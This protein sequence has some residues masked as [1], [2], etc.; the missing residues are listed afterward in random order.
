MK[1]LVINCGS[2]SVKFQFINTKSR[3]KLASGVAEM[4]AQDYSLFSYKN[5]NGY[6]LTKEKTHFKDHEEAINEF[7]KYIESNEYGVIK[8]R[9]EIDGI[10]HRVV[11]G[12]EEFF[13]SVMINDKLIQVMKNLSFLAPLH[14]PANIIGIEI[15]KKLFP[16]TAQCGVFDTAFHHNMPKYAFLYPIPLNL[17]YKHKI[18]K[19]GFHGTS[20]RFVYSRACEILGVDKNSIKAISCHL[21]NGASLAAINNGKSLDTS[22]GLTP[23][24]GLM[25]G[26]RSG[27]IDPSIPLFM[28][29]Q[30][31]YSLKQVSDTL[32]KKSGYYG[33][34][35]GITDMREIHEEISNNNDNC[36]LALDIYCYRLK[37]YIAS[38]LAVLNGADILIFTGGVG[39]ND[40]IV[41]ENTIKNIDYLGLKLDLNK[42]IE[43]NRKE[44]LISS[45]DS[46]IPI[47]IIPTD[48]E[49]LIALD[50]V[51]II[52]GE[53]IDF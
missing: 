14:N 6:K 29:E 41:R 2:S 22:M 25:M 31:G 17:Y 9:N 50:T 7:I 33:I 21:G 16:K 30:L 1:I 28:I 44:A 18:K 32:N 43:L 45:F 10:G 49:L 42:N 39:E 4:I 13:S 37:K 5:H 24:E 40:E 27:D 26:T 36:K 3:L 46:K 12:G 8:N 38:Y 53:K 47:Y 34:T 20:H 51:K 23:L 52:S 35:D 15:C 11:H 48:E 19:Y